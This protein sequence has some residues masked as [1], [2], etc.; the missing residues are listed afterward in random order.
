MTT[1][2]KNEQENPDQ[3]EVTEQVRSAAISDEDL[4]DLSGGVRVVKN[5][6]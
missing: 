5:P 4:N 3:K 6:T 2:E 1:P